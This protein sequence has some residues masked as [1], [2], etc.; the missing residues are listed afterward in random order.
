MAAGLICRRCGSAFRADTRKQVFCGISC[1]RKAW[2]E[3]HPGFQARYM[4]ERRKG[5]TEPQRTEYHTKYMRAY[6]QKP[7]VRAKNEARGILHRAIRAGRIKRQS[8]FCG[9]RGQAH[10]PNYAEPLRVEWLC[11]KHHAEIHRKWR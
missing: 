11:R 7:E 3:A 9:K 1:R 10:H 8:C 2:L 6:R 4:R 5:I